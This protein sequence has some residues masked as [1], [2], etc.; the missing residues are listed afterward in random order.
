MIRLFYYLSFLLFLNSCSNIQFVLKD[1]EPNNYLKGITFLDIDTDT[2]S[3]LSRE[4]FAFFDSAKKT[5][6]ILKISSTETKE[7]RMVQKNQVA[8]KIDYKIT[9]NY[10]L[11]LGSKSCKILSKKIV[12]SFSFV[13]K[14]SGYNFGADRSLEKLYIASVRKNISDFIDISQNDNNKECIS[15]N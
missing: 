12:T 4:L 13:P 8:Q 3:M 6:Y 11:F 14:S 1:G 15:E 9:V 5:E 2:N 7:N 10:L